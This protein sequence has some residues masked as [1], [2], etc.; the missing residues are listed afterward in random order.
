MKRHIICI[1]AALA[2]CTSIQLLAQPGRNGYRIE[3]SIGMV[4]F[5]DI[6]VKGA[7]CHTFRDLGYGYAKDSRHVYRYGEILEYVDPASFRVDKRFGPAYGDDTAPGYHKPL[8]PGHGRPGDGVHHPDME[9]GDY[10]KTAFDVFYNGRK[11]EGAFA[12]TFEILKNGYAK[13]AFHVYWK[14]EVVQDASSSTFK[15]L[16]NG[17]A[18]DAFHTYYYGRRI[19]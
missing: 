8:R 9:C 10:H 19:D 17:Y 13:D 3:Q 6:P 2:I 16:E 1:A 7:D 11:I 12:S 18:E 4:Y 5:C 14:G 15:V